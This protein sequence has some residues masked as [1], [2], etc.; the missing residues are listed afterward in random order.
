LGHPVGAI[1]IADNPADHHEHKDAQQD[2]R[3]ERWQAEPDENGGGQDPS[4]HPACAL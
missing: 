2:Q 1:P 3:G 4:R